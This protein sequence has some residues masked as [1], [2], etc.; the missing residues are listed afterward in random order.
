[1]YYSHWTINSLK[2]RKQHFAFSGYNIYTQ[3]LGLAHSWHSEKI[4]E[5]TDRKVLGEMNGKRNEST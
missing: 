4:M 3:K 5:M 1:M 2:D